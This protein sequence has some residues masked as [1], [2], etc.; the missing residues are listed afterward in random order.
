EWL[1]G[2]FFNRR[3][4]A[5]VP[6]PSPSALVEMAFQFFLFFGGKVFH[7][8]L[9]LFPCPSLPLLLPFVVFHEAA[10]KQFAKDEQA[11]GLPEGD[12]GA[13]EKFGHQPVPEQHHRQAEGGRAGHAQ[14]DEPCYFQSLKTIIMP[15]LYAFFNSLYNC[16]SLSRR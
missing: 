9:H 1:F 2:L 16:A 12:D 5:A 14:D 15:H 11:Q 10:E 6:P 4:L 7:A 8:G 3:F 13:V